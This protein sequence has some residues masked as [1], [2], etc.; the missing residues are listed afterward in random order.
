M[1]EEN[2]GKVIRAKHPLTFGQGL[3]HSALEE[4]FGLI[5]LTGARWTRIH[6]ALL[7]LGRERPAEEIRIQLC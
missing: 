4:L 5:R 1:G 2:N 3:L 6:D 7:Y